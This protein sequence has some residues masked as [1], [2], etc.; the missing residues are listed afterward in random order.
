MVNQE[1]IMATYNNK[2][3]SE[4]VALFLL[5]TVHHDG[6]LNHYDKDTEQ[7]WTL[8]AAISAP[9]WIGRCFL[10]VLFNST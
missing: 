8:N 5:S 6:S 10:L 3:S 1:T 9:Q 7:S 4:W 2:V